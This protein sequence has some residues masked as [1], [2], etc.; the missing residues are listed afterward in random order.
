MM[1]T[2]LKVVRQT[3]LKAKDE[4]E[5]FLVRK[6]SDF[7]FELFNLET[8][9]TVEKDLLVINVPNTD[10]T[11]TR[12]SSNVIWLSFIIH[13]HAINGFLVEF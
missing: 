9:E 3:N 5:Y 12:S 2:L 8:L 7:F 6:I 11:I 10:I 4:T 13:S 1:A